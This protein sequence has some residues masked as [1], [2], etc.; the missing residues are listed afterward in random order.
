[1]RA[2]VCQGEL[3]GKEA[4]PSSEPSDRF[5][6]RRGSHCQ[7]PLWWQSQYFV[8]SVGW[9]LEEPAHW[10]GFQGSDKP[11]G[12]GSWQGFPSKMC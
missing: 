10:L 11:T 1:M 5:I 9:G 6:E 12:A 4:R 8:K 2:R 3:A 7:F